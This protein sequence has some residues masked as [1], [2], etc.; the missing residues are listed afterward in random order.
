MKVRVDFSEAV[1][2][3]QGPPKEVKEEAKLVSR[4]KNSMQREQPEQK[5]VC[6]AN[7]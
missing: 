4:K 3:E 1:T 2:F 5:P 7:S 6:T